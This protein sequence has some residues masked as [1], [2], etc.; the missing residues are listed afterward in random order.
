[1]RGSEYFHS[2]DPVEAV[3]FVVSDAVAALWESI[4]RQGG[5]A[6]FAGQVPAQLIRWESEYGWTRGGYGQVA[7]KETSLANA[8]ARLLT[9]PDMWRTFT[10]PYLKAL[11]AAGRGEPRKPR[12]SYGSF[13]DTSFRREQRTGDLA[14]RLRR[15]ISVSARTRTRSRSIFGSAS[16]SPNSSNS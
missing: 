1:M 2:E 13:D 14:A 10:E 7:E 16:W 9:A 6:A 11:E 4:L 3:R 12:T 5:F 15:A 8:L